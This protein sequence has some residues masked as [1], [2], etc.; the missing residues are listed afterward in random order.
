MVIVYVDASVRP[1]RTGGVGVVIHIDPPL[2]SKRIRI[3]L[4]MP[5]PGTLSSNHAEILACLCAARA[6]AGVSDLI[7]GLKQTVVVIKTDSAA[8]VSAVTNPSRV[9]SQQTRAIAKTARDAWDDLRARGVILGWHLKKI[10][11][12]DNPADACAAG[13][14]A[15][16]GEMFTCPPEPP[17]KT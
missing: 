3:P 14:R 1:G 2:E 9:R 5:I 11:R 6:L 15:L 4:E 10:G 12:K 16:Y 13:A 7:L 8:A 17:Q